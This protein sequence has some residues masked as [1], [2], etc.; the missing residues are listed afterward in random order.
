MRNFFAL[1]FFVIFPSSIFAYSPIRPEAHKRN[2]PNSEFFIEFNP[3]TDHHTVYAASSPNT[4]LWSNQCDSFWP[5]RQ[6]ESDGCLFVS[7]NGLS[8][9]GP[10][11]V[12]QTGSPADHRV[13]D[14]LEFW[15]ANGQLAAYRVS[16][17]P[18]WRLNIL[19]FPVRIVWTAIHGTQRRGQNISRQEDELYITTFGMRSF[20]FSLQTGKITGWNL[21]VIYFAYFA[22]VYAIP[23]WILKRW[24]VYRWR[25]P[26]TT[27]EEQPDAGS[28]FFLKNIGALLVVA[29]SLVF[30]LGIFFN[31]FGGTI[32]Q[33]GAQFCRLTYPIAFLLIPITLLISAAGLASQPRRIDLLGPWLAIISGVILVALFRVY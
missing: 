5:Y 11:W 21:N 23:V 10:T 14:G 2:S 32:D 13:F 33:I 1:A 28:G 6:D 18:S 3:L 9:A 27:K 25:S 29:N 19:D 22:L 8:I 17:L 12:H 20:T 15:D 31:A 4:P 26:A 30:T 16:E 7:N 24:V